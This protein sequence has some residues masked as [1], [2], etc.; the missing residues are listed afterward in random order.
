MRRECYHRSGECTRSCAMVQE[1][2][3]TAENALHTSVGRSWRR[4]AG[5]PVV[6]QLSMLGA[7]GGALISR[8]RP[9]ATWRSREGRLRGAS[10]CRGAPG[11]RECCAWPAPGGSHSFRCAGWMRKLMPARPREPSALPEGGQVFWQRK[12]SQ[13]SICSSAAQPQHRQQHVIASTSLHQGSPTEGPYHA[14]TTRVQSGLKA[15]RWQ[16]APAWECKGRPLQELRHALEAVKVMQCLQICRAALCRCS[17][18]GS[19]MDSVS[20]TQVHVLLPCQLP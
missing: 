1:S 6:C 20:I 11:S 2:Q 19:T 3:G 16:T 14:W 13:A 18:L 15:A 7:S 12:G 5:T 10:I 4:E 17:Y 8:V 9:P